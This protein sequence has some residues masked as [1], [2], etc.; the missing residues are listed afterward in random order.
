MYILHFLT[1]L[2]YFVY[3]FLLSTISFLFA[4]GFFWR[5]KGSILEKEIVHRKKEWANIVN[6]R[7]LSTFVQNALTFQRQV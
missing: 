4:M 1:L 2:L 5:K 7:T 6:P 3:K